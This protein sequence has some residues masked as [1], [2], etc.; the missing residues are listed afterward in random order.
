MVET[1]RYLGDVAIITTRSNAPGVTEQRFTFGDHLGSVETITDQNGS[2]VEHVNF[3]PH[4]T[5]R[6]TSDWQGPG[7]AASTTTRG[8]TG[9]EHIDGVGLIHMNA[10][11]FDPELGRFLQADIVVEAPSNLQSWN[12][13]T[14]V[15][16]NPL[17]LTDPTG[18]VS[19]KPPTS[20]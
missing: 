15:F 19:D 7:I 16:N 6:D 8:F 4:G 14:Y 12:R 13:Y 1:K 2:V 3:D 18:R 20:D 11:I 5:R 9:H 17:S 10:R